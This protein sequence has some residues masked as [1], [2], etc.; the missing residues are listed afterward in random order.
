MKRIPIVVVRGLVIAALLFAGSNILAQ[1]AFCSTPVCGSLP[2]NT[3]WSLINSPYI[4]CDPGGAGVTVPTG[5]TLT[6]DPG[7]TVQFAAVATNKLNIQGTLVANGTVTQP[8]TLTGLVAT[9][10]SWGGISAIGTV[11]APAHV[12]LDYVK[13]Q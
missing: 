12:N 7:V 9:K 10:G 3:T 1:T 6:I 8:I 2:G 13:N 5:V 11:A 4:V